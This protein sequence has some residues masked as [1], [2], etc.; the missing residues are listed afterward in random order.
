MP[1]R[2]SPCRSAVGSESSRGLGNV[3]PNEH[4]SLIGSH[5]PL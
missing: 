1:H 4:G 5:R 2:A 3:C